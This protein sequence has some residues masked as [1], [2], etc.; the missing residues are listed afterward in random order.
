MSNS[1]FRFTLFKLP[2]FIFGLIIFFLPITDMM[3][4]N[5]V[6]VY[7]LEKYVE[8]DLD[9]PIDSA[10]WQNLSEGLNISWASRDIHYEKYQVPYLKYVSDTMVWGWKGERVNLMAV[11]F[12]KS[13]F[14]EVSLRMTPWIK[15]GF[16][17][18]INS[19]Q[20]RFVNYVITDDY[21]SCGYHPT[22]LPQWL[23]A[24]V[25]DMDLSKDI[26]A[27]E[28]RP[29]WCTVEV[30]R[31]IC[32]G[33][34]YTTMEV[35]GKDGKILG[36][37]QLKINVVNRTLPEVRHQKFHLDLW[38]QPY[39][40]SRYYGVERWSQGH[41][42]ALRP[43]LEAL[44]R[45]GQRSVTAIM[46][47]EP[48]GE[49]TYYEDKFDP[50]IDV[51]KSED[52]S[53]EYDYADF[54]KYVELCDE[55]GINHQINCYS[56]VPWDM[57]F[58]YFDKA[59]NDY[60]F[61][62]TSTSHEDYRTLW[63]DFLYSFKEH[64]IEK[65][66]FE[67]TNIAM[68]ERSP[69]D[70][71]NAYQIAVALGFKVAL[72]GNYHSSLSE[73]IQDYSVAIG[74]DKMF[75]AA[76]LSSR[77]SKGQITTIYTSCADK[78]PNIFT[79]SLPA[80]A[81][82][83]P[84]YAAAAGLDGY[85][86]WSWI[87]WHENPLA[88]SRYRMF[89]SGDTYCYYPGNRSSVR[90][91]RLI[92]GIHQY[93]KVMILK[94]EFKN[95]PERLSRLNHLLEGFKDSSIDGKKCAEMVNEMEAFLN[96]ADSISVCADYDKQILF[97]TSD[98]D[99]IRAPY[100]IPALAS[101][102][103]GRLVAVAARLVCG[104]DPGFGRIDLVSR[105]SDDFGVT[106]SEI[107]EV[108]VGSGR[109]SAEENFFDTAFGDPAIVADRDGQGLLLMSVA[110]CTLFTDT[111]TNR[112]NPNLIAILRSEDNGASWSE[113]VDVTE[114]IYSLFDNFNPID[115]AFVT[116]GKIFQSRV[117]K[118]GEYYRIYAALC[119]RE[120]GNRVIFSDDFGESWKPLGGAEALPVEG[121]NE[122]KC[123][124]LEDGTLILSSRTSGGRLFN[125]FT[126]RNVRRGKGEWGQASKTDFSDTGY[127]IGRNSTNGEM[128]VVRAVRLS[129]GQECSLLLHSIPTADSREN[130]G[131]YFKELSFNSEVI[132]IDDIA[133]GW[134]GCYF[135]S[136][137]T[138]AYSTLVLQDDGKIALLF[139]EN[140]KWFGKRPNPVTTTF[141]TG[142]GFHNFDGYDIV[143]INYD[144]ETITS[145][146][147]K[148]VEAL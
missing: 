40:V 11:I 127:R 41:L 25:I 111:K 13:S 60:C 10:A 1:F 98:G 137:T 97:N 129:D 143:F 128:L 133:E 79:N 2:F 21:K 29:V 36:K 4:Q 77:K 94:E 24:D 141:P 50:M 107:S 62:K 46:F 114:V 144:L 42:Q 136:N 147:Y 146:R 113:P 53:W 44:A 45:A 124:E 17:T 132:D 117:I 8:P 72:A 5:N 51:I 120:G 81:A 20:A 86:H 142:E 76:E 93:E 64:L 26:S 37:L 43:Y 73:I 95:Q 48:W 34:Y 67:K 27:M 92:E 106:W 3:G 74:Q 31:D 32:S 135:V 30:P 118:V 82:Y 138:S 75:T 58:R 112:K 68:D 131:I 105:T 109:V 49:Q 123:E 119:V 110:G 122:A 70:V 22:D 85:L 56:M 65:G 140:Y 66:W 145:G 35:V 101:A 16:V 52:G 125:F 116:S 96:G 69:E 80:E 19:A 63:S 91:E 148:L 33:K 18:Q 9:L 130:L 78:E 39:S 83:I 15:D 87:N 103:H 100:R 108:A 14:E 47:Y 38:Q 57:N 28:T 12:S 71:S 121:G 55:Y 102:K 54:D 126:Y 134:T 59:I 61:L 89:G 99:G 6:S 88:D 115:A 23:V 139:E 90:F 7:P 84:L 104:T